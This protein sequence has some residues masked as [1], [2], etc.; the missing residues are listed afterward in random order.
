VESH[1]LMPLGWD[2]DT[3]LFSH[4]LGSWDRNVLPSLVGLVWFL[5][6]LFRGEGGGLRLDVP[7]NRLRPFRLAS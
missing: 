4:S 6:G 5:Y 1:R 2:Q 7:R 3:G